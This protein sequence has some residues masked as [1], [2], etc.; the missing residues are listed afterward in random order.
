M[1]PVSSRCST[2]DGR[3]GAVLCPQSRLFRITV[4]KPL[5]DGAVGHAAFIVRRV[6]G[7]CAKDPLTAEN[8]SSTAVTV[9][10]TPA[11]FLM[12]M[13]H[14]MVDSRDSSDQD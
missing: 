13:R 11:D 1:C 8:R 3:E 4:N 12:T 5:K 6:S 7:G 10:V 2:T 9:T 14:G